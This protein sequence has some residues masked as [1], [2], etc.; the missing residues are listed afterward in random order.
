MYVTHGGILTQTRQ[1]HLVIF[2]WKRLIFK[3]FSDRR[4][5]SQILSRVWL[6][7]L[8]ERHAEVFRAVSWQL[9]IWLP[10]ENKSPF[11]QSLGLISHSYEKI[12]NKRSVRCLFYLTRCFPILLIVVI[13]L[14]LCY[15]SIGC[16][17]PHW[18]MAEE[19]SCV[20]ACVFVWDMDG[21]GVVSVESEQEVA[22]SHQ[23]KNLWWDCCF[24]SG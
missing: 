16:H 21:V 3:T 18:V 20:C 23:V 8:R 22:L 10:F 2:L 4:F 13:K 15:N 11:N 7:E 1:Y 12:I 19:E 17:H 5:T 14:V 24:V 6:T 9:T